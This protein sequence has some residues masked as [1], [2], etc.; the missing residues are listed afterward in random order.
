MP[1]SVV[2][3]RLL[4]NPKDYNVGYALRRF[5]LEAMAH[6]LSTDNRTEL[7]A[8]GLNLKAAPKLRRLEILLK[9]PVGP[10]YLLP[11][12]SFELKM[13]TA[14]HTVTLKTEV[15]NFHGELRV[16]NIECQLDGGPGCHLKKVYAALEKLNGVP[17]P[18]VLFRKED[19]N[20]NRND[21]EDVTLYL[22]FDASSDPGLARETATRSPTPSRPPVGAQYSVDAPYGIGSP[23]SPYSTG[24]PLSPSYS[25]SSSPRYT[26]S[27]PNYSVGPSTPPT[28]P[29]VS[30]QYRARSR[31][32]SR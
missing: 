14:R 32:R 17:I 4:K 28:T 13:T 27:S 3:G 19:W 1:S 26:V 8:S 16:D 24:A 6:H 30:P 22:N 23:F 29:P 10:W 25:V 12:T 11:S 9:Y 5:V 7:V 2:F 20:D 31:S 21:S 18:A 15:N